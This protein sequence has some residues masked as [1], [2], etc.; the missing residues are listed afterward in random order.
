MGTMKHAE[1][2]LI[3]DFSHEAKTAIQKE[4]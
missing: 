4:R 3:K 2:V 1:I